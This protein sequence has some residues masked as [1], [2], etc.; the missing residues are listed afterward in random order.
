MLQNYIKSNGS[1]SKFTTTYHPETNGMIERLHRWI[2]ERL[3]LIAFDNG[4]NFVDGTD[5]WS[6]YLNIIL[7]QI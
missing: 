1:K 5:D 7:L 2:K 6:L 3:A 4:L